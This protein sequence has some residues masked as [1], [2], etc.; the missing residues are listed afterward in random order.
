MRKTADEIADEVLGQEAVA[1]KTKEKW[2]SSLVGSAV[3]TAGGLASRNLGVS[4]LPS[5]AIMAGLMGLVFAKAPNAI[6]KNPV[7]NANKP[8]WWKE[9][10]SPMEQGLVRGVSTGLGTTG[11]H[12]LMKALKNKGLL[13]PEFL[14]SPKG[15]LA[16]IGLLTV[17]SVAGYLLSDK[18]MEMRDERRDA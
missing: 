4:S 16:T 12:F 5:E 3:G 14:K 13:T 9:D 15:D 18:L 8:R 6:W 2:I 17:P 11:G 10:N 7:E 1:R